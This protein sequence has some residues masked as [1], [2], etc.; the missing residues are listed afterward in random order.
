MLLYQEELAQAVALIVD[1][2]VLYEGNCEECELKQ[3]CSL[4]KPIDIYKED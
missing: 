4:N 3:F 2:C 1:T